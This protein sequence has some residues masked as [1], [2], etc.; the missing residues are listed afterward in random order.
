[1]SAVK[2]NLGYKCSNMDIPCQFIDRYISNCLPVYPLIYIWSLRRLLDGKHS[3]FRE[4]GDEF[5]LTEGDVIKAWQHWNSMGLV[6]FVADEDG[7]GSMSVTFLPENEWPKHGEQN[8]EPKSNI[9][10]LPKLETKPFYSP[11]ELSCYTERSEEIRGLFKRGEEALGKLLTHNDMN[12][13]FSFYDWLRLPVDVIE[14]LLSYCAEN[15]HRNLRYMEKCA[16][17]WSDKQIDSLEKALEYVQAFDRDYRTILFHMGLSTGYPTPGHKKYMDKWLDSWRM[18]MD[19]I[20]RACEVSIEHIDRPKF[21][22]VDRILTLWHKNKVISLK[23]AENV[24]LEPLRSGKSGASAKTVKPKQN[25]F[26]NFKQRNTD[27]AMLEKLEREYLE[28]K[29]K[30]SE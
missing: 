27:Y 24:D 25:R 21:N 14:Y 13:I 22:Y 15:D 6:E 4:I 29:L 9:I 8:K 30:V 18:S 11:E 1:M 19:L 23:Q 5:A 17:D 2:M 16:I 20:I 7:K 26:V 10:V 28:Q 3:S 12:V